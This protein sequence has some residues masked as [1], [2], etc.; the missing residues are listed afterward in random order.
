[1]GEDPVVQHLVASAGFGAFD[2]HVQ[3]VGCDG[4]IVTVLCVPTRIWRDPESR[5][6]LLEVKVQ[7]RALRTCCILVPQR[8]LRAPV[9]SSVA[10][11]LAGTRHT[12]YTRRQMTDALSHIDE[13]RITSII[14]AASAIKDHDDPVGAILSMVCRGI[15]DIDR[16]KPIDADTYAAVA[17]L[18]PLPGTEGEKR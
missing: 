12:T 7:A 1:M 13:L 9:R 5:R 6:L 16:S 3:R 2:I 4:P 15:V 10:R 18:A 8:W 14:E 11:V 17:L